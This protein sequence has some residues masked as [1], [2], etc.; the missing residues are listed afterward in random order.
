MLDAFEGDEYWQMRVVEA[1]LRGG[2]TQ[3]SMIAQ[4]SPKSFVWAVGRLGLVELLPLVRDLMRHA[5]NKL[6]LIGITIWAY[7]KL[8]AYA[9]IEALEPL[10]LELE[11]EHGFDALEASL[12]T[13]IESDDS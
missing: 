6:A 2:P 4:L 1:A 7:G 9:D 12:R 10:V 5:N 3:S 11:T 8:H 13:G